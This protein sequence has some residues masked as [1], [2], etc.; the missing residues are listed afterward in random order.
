MPE[1]A[2]GGA[3]AM[4]NEIE[5]KKESTPLD[6][7]KMSS[8]LASRVLFWPARYRRESSF[9][10]HMPLA[11][12]LMDVVKPNILIEV[13]LDDGQGY[14]GF[15]QAMERLNMAGRCYG[16]SEEAPEE[17]LLTHN[18]ENYQ[19]FSTIAERP[20]A[21]ALRRFKDGTID[22]LVVNTALPEETLKSLAD[23]WSRKLSDRSVILL[24]NYLDQPQEAVVQ[25]MIDEMN[26]KNRIITFEK[27]SGLAVVLHGKQQDERLEHLAG[28]EFGTP[29]Y[30][31]VHSVFNRLG[32]AHYYE[33]SSRKFEKEARAARGQAKQALADLKAKEEALETVRSELNSLKTAY[34]A[35]SEKV[36]EMQ[37]SLFDLQQEHAKE[38]AK[39]REQVLSL[40]TSLTQE[41]A[42]READQKRADE[43]AAE[44][45]QA[46]QKAEQQARAL[47]EEIETLTASL[48]EAEAKRD[49]AAAERDKARQ[50]VEGTKNVH[51][52]EVVALTR[53]LEEQEVSIQQVAV[54]HEQERQNTAKE[55]QTLQKKL[56]ETAERHEFD[57]QYQQ[58]QVRLRELLINRLRSHNQKKL[59]ERLTRRNR[60]KEDA[61]VLAKSPNFDAE[62]YLT[63]YPDVRES[64]IDP[65]LHFLTD[66]FYEGRSPGPD[67]DCVAYLVD[68]PDLLEKDINPLIHALE[69]DPT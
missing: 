39:L 50:Q 56:R 65:A 31:M 27:E 17:T 46:R 7:L 60:L 47:R 2:E 28:I 55:I 33:W 14:F 42:A 32:N 36:A 44:R 54:E 20:A 8:P 45:D 12:W 69:N 64:G 49:E 4:K 26:A 23:V 43:A 10:Y 52:D 63:T 1:H 58:V 3:D 15:C 16:F 35:R 51:T 18:N 66:G 30:N 67:F 9:L 5:A 41:Q 19:E 29:E 61:R 68:H 59:S 57:K 53:K 48:K 40:Q 37:A 34:E 62:W 13:G 22:V 6:R 24:H 38:D 11:F 25:E 21:E